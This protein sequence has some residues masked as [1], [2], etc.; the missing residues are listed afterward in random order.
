MGALALIMIMMMP[1]TSL[2]LR[3]HCLLS[4]FLF[5]LRR[6]AWAIV[7]TTRKMVW[8]NALLQLPRHP[9]SRWVRR[10]ET[11]FKREGPFVCVC[12]CEVM[13]WYLCIFLQ[14]AV[15]CRLVFERWLLIY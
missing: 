6:Y 14:R 15:L 13:H 1:R 11:L 2:L 5:L 4:V 3:L 10:R 7:R 9:M 8:T 12:A